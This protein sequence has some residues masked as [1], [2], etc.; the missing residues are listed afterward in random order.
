MSTVQEF[1][2]HIQ[3]PRTDALCRSHEARARDAQMRHDPMVY[4]GEKI[5]QI[6]ELRKLAR[7]LERE[8]ADTR[9]RVAPPGADGTAKRDRNWIAAVIVDVAELPDR[10]SPEGWPEAM[11]V[12][13]EELRTIIERHVAPPEATGLVSDTPRTVLPDQPTAEAIG[14]LQVYWPDATIEKL[15]EI[16]ENLLACGTALPEVGTHD[17][18]KEAV[19]DACTVSWVEWDENDPR[20]TLK[21][22]IA[23]EVEWALDPQIS[24]EAQDLIERGKRE[25]MNRDD[26]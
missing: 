15:T 3:T 6:M 26:K 5:A 18:W 9:T 20:A 23:R 14:L 12:T 17:K 22:L 24:K 10:D 13:G 1:G 8:L 16:Y 4:A 19:L 7:E 11:I 21:A 2:R 25:C